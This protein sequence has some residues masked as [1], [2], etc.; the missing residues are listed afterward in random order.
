MGV[1]MTSTYKFSRYSVSLIL[2]EYHQKVLN[3]QLTLHKV[4]SQINN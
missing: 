2:S 1:G 4:A 3:F